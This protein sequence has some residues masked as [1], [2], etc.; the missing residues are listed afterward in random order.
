MGTRFKETALSLLEKY[1]VALDNAAN[2]P[3]IASQLNNIGFTADVLQEGKALYDKAVQA[4]NHNLREDNETL[5]SRAKFDLLREEVYSEYML[6]RKKAKVIF[7]ADSV[8]LHKLLLTG[9]MPESYLEM[10]DVITTFYF[11]ALADNAIIDKLRRLAITPEAL[12]ASSNK[13]KELV[14]SRA[15]YLREIGE[16]QDA[17][18]AKDA[19]ILAL[20]RWMSDFFT[21]A[22][23]AM[24]D[25]PQ[26]LEALGITVK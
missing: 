19:A 11:V 1:R 16:S 23:I 9:S 12:T 10:V 6:Y 8:V 24:E 26:L 25:N 13:V 14:D 17:T 20:S 4:Y 2:Q 21:V 22:K 18:K 15:H 7:R 3:E 5:D